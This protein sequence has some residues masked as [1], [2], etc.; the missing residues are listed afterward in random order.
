MGI[1]ENDIHYQYAPLVF[2]LVVLYGKCELACVV[3]QEQRTVDAKEKFAEFVASRGLRRTEQRDK[4][5]DVFLATEKHVTVQELYDLIRTRHM[6]VE[7]M[8]RPAP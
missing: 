1:Y 6:G 4:V 3:L 7:N 5:V 8:E 2:R